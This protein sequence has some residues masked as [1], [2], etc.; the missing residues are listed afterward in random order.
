M[1]I[2]F[3]IL[4]DEN[5]S[6]FTSLRRLYTDL[7]VS[8]SVSGRAG[9]TGTC[10]KREFSTIMISITELITGIPLILEKDVIYEST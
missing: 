7:Y 5:F 4:Q 1:R 6:T 8:L 3:T 9:W 10:R 2:S